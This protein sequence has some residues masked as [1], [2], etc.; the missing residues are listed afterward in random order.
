MAGAGDSRL[1]PTPAELPYFPNEGP[2]AREYFVLIAPREHP[3]G[4]VSSSLVGCVSAIGGLEPQS[5]KLQSPQVSNLPYPSHSRPGTVPTLT[6]YSRGRWHQGALPA[7]NAIGLPTTRFHTGTPRTTQMD[8][9]G[10]RWNSPLTLKPVPVS[11]VVQYHRTTFKTEYLGRY[12]KGL[13]SF[14]RRDE[15]LSLFARLLPSIATLVRLP[16]V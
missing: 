16:T 2:K 8:N 3:K 9:Q 7:I 10:A 4:S 6:G 14:T 13:L 15:A 1:S 5:P 11:Q 12:L